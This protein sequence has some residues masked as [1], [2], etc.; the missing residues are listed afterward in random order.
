MMEGESSS[1]NIRAIAN[2][3][4]FTDIIFSWSLEDI[5]NENLYKDQVENIA[6]S[7]E[8]IHHYRGSFVYP[9]FE[10]TRAQ[11]CYGNHLRSTF[12]ENSKPETVHDLQRV[13]RS[14][15]FLSVS[16]ITEDENEDVTSTYFKVNAFKE[17]DPNEWKQKSLFVVFL[18]NITP[19]RRIWS[20]LH[21][22][23]NLQ[24]NKEILCTD[25]LVSQ[26]CDYCSPWG[27]P[28][29]DE[30]FLER[31]SSKL[32]KSQHE[33]I[34]ACLSTVQCCHKSTVE[35]IWGPPGTGKT[36][37]LSTLLFTLLK[38]NFKVLT[39][40]TTNVAI[41]EVASR[42]LTLKKESFKM[43]PDVLFCSLGDM[44]L[45]GNNERL[46]VGSEIEDIYLEYRV[47]QL[48]D[49]FA[50]STGWRVCF[51]SLID[52]LE[53]C[54]SQYHIY[55]ENELIKEKEHLDTSEIKVKK[56]INSSEAKSYIL[57]H[58]FDNMV[59]LIEILDSFEALLFQDTAVSE[60]V[61]DVFSLPQLLESSSLSFTDMPYMLYKMRTDC[62]SVLNTLKQSLGKL[63]LP[64]SMSKESIQEFCFRTSSLIFATA[65]SSY[66]LHFV[67]MEPLNILVIDEAAQLKECESLIPL[68][69]PGIRHAILVGDE[70]QL[71]AT[72][73]SN[74]S[75]EAGFGRSL[76]E[77]LSLL[78]HSKHLLNIQYQMHPSISFFPNSYFY[79]NQIID[80]PNV[81]RKSYE[82]H[83]LP[84]PMF[85]PYSFINIVGG[86]EEL[87]DAGRSRRNMI[88][89]AIV[90]K[91]LKKLHKA[92]VSPK[93]K[94]SIGVV[95]PYAAQVVSIQ[96][97][98][99]KKYDAHDGFVVNVKSIDG[100]QGGEHDI[101]IIST[102]RTNSRAS[103]EFISNPLRINVALTR[104]RHCLW[105]LGSERTLASDE[106]VWE[107]I[108]LDAKN[109]QCF[110]NADEDKDMTKAILDVKKELDQFDDLLNKDSVLFRSARWKVLFFS[111]NFL[112]SFKKLRSDR[113]KKSVVN[114]LLKLSS[115]SSGWRPKKGNMDSFCGSSSQILK[116]FKVEGLYLMCSIDIV[117]ES[118]Y[119]QVLKIWDILSPEDIPKLEKRLDGIFGRYT[120]DFIN[121]C[122]EKCLEGNLEVPMSWRTSVDVI[123][124]RD[125]TNV[126]NED[127]LSISGSEGRSFVENSKVGES[128]LLMKF[129]SLSSS[130]VSHLL[131]DRD[132]LELDL[133]FAVTDEELEM[134]LYPKSTFILGRSG[135]GKTTV[136]TMKLFQKEKLHQMATEAFYGTNRIAPSCSMKHHVTRLKRS[137]SDDTFP[138]ES[139]SNDMEDIDDA[140]IQFKNIPDSF[141]DVSP[142][143]YPLLITFHKFLMMLEWDFGTLDSCRVFT[144]IISHIKGSPQTEETCDG[145]LSR[146]DYVLLSESR[147]SSLSRQMREKRYDIFQDYEKMK[148]KNG[149]FDLA[150]LVIDL[151]RRLRLKKY[152]GLEMDFVYI[153]EVQDLT[154]SQIALFKYIS[155]N[156]EEGFVFSGDTAQTIARGIDFRFQ[157]IRCLFYQKFVLESRSRTNDELKEK[158]K[159]SD[160]FHLSQNFRTHAG[161]LR[162][163]QSII[164]LLYQFFPQSIDVL[165]P[166][167]S[168][169]YGEAPVLLESGNSENAIVK[170][171]GN[172]ENIG[173]KIVGFGAEQVILVRDDGARKEILNYVGKHALVLTILECKGL[174]FQDVLLYNFFGSS[175]FKNKWRVIYEYMKEQDLLNSTAAR[176]YS[177]F[178][179]SKH[180][181]LCSKLKQLYVAVTR[182]R[183]RLWICENIEDFSKPI[184]DYWKKK[185]LVQARQLDDSF[186]QAMQVASTPEEW[187]SRGI[188]LYHECNYEMATMCFER[189]GDTYWERREAADL[190]ESI[191]KADSAAQCFSDVGDYEK[192]GKLYLEKS[193]DPD[194]KRAGDCFSLAGCCELAAQVYARGNFF[195]NCL[196][197]CAEGRLFDVGLDYI[198]H[199]RQIETTAAGVIRR[200]ELDKIEE[201]FL[202]R[203]ARHYYRLKDTRSMMRFVKA[204]RSMDL[205]R[206]FLRSSGLFDELLLLEEELGNF[207]EAA[208]IAKLRGDILLEA[209]LL[210]K[211]EVDVLSNEQSNIFT[212]MTN[213]NLT[214]RRKSIRGEILS[215]RKILDAH[216]ELNS[217][218]YVWQDEVIVDSAKYME[219]LVFKNQVSVDTL[220]YFWKCWKE[221][222]VNILEYL[223]CIDV[224]EYKNYGQFAFNFLGVWKQISNMNEIYLLLNPDADWVKKMCTNF[225]KRNGKLVSVDVHPIISAAR[226]YWCSELLSVGMRVLNNLEALHRFSVKNTISVFCQS[227]SLTLIYEVAKFLLDSKFL[228][229]SY[230]N[231]KPLEKF[232]RFSFEHF[233]DYVFPLDWRKSLTE[234][235][236]SLRQTEVSRCLL[237]EIIHENIRRKGRLTYG[238]LGRVAVMILGLGVLDIELCEEI[239][240]K[241]DDNSPR[242]VFIECFCVNTGPQLPQGSVAGNVTESQ[243]MVYVL[244]KFYEALED[245]YNANWRR[246]NDYISPSCFLY[247]VE[248]LLILA[249]YHKGYIFLTRSSFLEWFLFQDGNTTQNLSVMSD[250]KPSLR[251]IDDFIARVIN[252][253]LFNKEETKEW[254][255]RSNTNVKH[256]YP[257]CSIVEQLPQAFY[258][259]LRKSKK[260]N[261]LA[262]LNVFAEAFEKIDDPLVIVRLNDSSEISCRNAFL[263]DLM[264]YRHKEDVVKMMFPK[265][266]ESVIGEAASVEEATNSCSEVFSSSV[267]GLKDS[268][269]TAVAGHLSNIKLNNEVNLPLGYNNVLELFDTLLLTEN[270]KDRDTLLSNAQK[271]KDSVNK[272][273][274]FLNAAGTEP[275]HVKPSNKNLFSEVVDELEQLSTA[276]DGREFCQEDQNLS[277]S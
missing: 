83:Y 26:T 65:S 116:R 66:K 240:G 112:K 203:C 265:K 115:G 155:Q 13:G 46:K 101:I 260:Q 47:K 104:A 50:P 69:L 166:E 186:V 111:D 205:M 200:H 81:K 156:V 218:K 141:I 18:I 175:P 276:L 10:E 114:L 255:R 194:L 181:V 223:A 232:V 236:V 72:V 180:G 45:L 131:S 259:V 122:K 32:N 2:D 110:F 162:L 15:T 12:W 79:L 258:G 177:R 213:L 82:K 242:K 209:D 41:K 210:G 59:H 24:L 176:S 35:L 269:F 88:E 204:F 56:A 95:S 217:P 100:F 197:V 16:K 254:I 170:I 103:L 233:N 64:S 70:C 25:N 214:R 250:V 153:D 178:N 48:S 62:L 193:C 19:N 138:M 51:A 9:L 251:N 132:G 63:D 135:T 144:E 234:N 274:Q 261:V 263:V 264:V 93:V 154:M 215:L 216:F 150:D 43:R 143:S 271:M 182:T 169:I 89:V 140:T 159:I 97:K 71:P 239:I 124:F 4:G 58:N 128:L 34:L 91:I 196:T 211:A 75:Q 55:L 241:I 86:R 113:T 163:S 22:S 20:A 99:G 109:R 40:A 168:F 184:F 246:K 73:K 31:E 201:N 191:G 199:W 5:F 119:I 37:T 23:G 187:K 11:L 179:E 14:W 224:S 253:L 227:R 198:Q 192:A 136:L 222:V 252:A 98:L 146:E 202:E 221:K 127:E 158:A 7:F 44:L 195:S 173:R 243:K 267:S 60:L 219:G 76:F 142:N 268:N 90:M 237:K 165:K 129:Y 230:G 231:L 229:H 247:L 125:L 174:E 107:A 117:K 39:C 235:M 208:N 52:L 96:E 137:I 120:D 266:V 61:E 190:F 245:T 85:G 134:I 33:A 275:L 185:F 106:A 133:P 74:V 256:Y 126:D 272:G 57:E 84:L 121:H 161:V 92:F 29:K 68:L 262:N 148:M 171:F 225:L 78:G 152:K 54:V 42:L 226:S 105:I 80:A 277:T 207:L 220:V 123:R 17:I 238:Q 183:Q 167:T 249:S 206:E 30:N 149:E 172:S 151:H 188:K 49:C 147:A 102:V 212:M 164:E 87:D 270:E 189:A 28:V 94:L 145:K 53:H 130:V 3:S 139:C 21:I 244:S 8:S 248:R 228:N 77:R 36:K 67:K 27:C 1:R 157:D 160:I 118:R 6:Q 38:V 257:C 273:I 108:L